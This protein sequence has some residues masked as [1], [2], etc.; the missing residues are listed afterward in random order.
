MPIVCFWLLVRRDGRE[1]LRVH[2]LLLF[3]VVVVEVEGG[4]LESVEEQAG[5]AAVDVVEGEVGD[6]LADGLL[7]GG[8]RGGLGQLDGVAAGVAGL[9]IGGGLALLV[10]EVAVALVAQGVAA[11]AVSVDEDVAAAEV[12]GCL[13]A[14]FGDLFVHGAPPWVS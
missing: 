11:A 1:F 5:A 14:L 7:D 3:L 13:A 2:F 8:A 10:V 12:L 6:D 9:R 4:D